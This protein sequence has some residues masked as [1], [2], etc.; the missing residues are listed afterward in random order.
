MV[1]V[2]YNPLRTKLVLSAQKMGIKA[3]C[4]LYMLIAQAVRASEIF[5]GEKYD[6]GVVGKV[7]RD[8]KKEK[9][10]VVLTGMPASGKS[11]VGKILAK[12]LNREFI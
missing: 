2:I 9:E 8:I 11:T 12:K 3:G 10:N 1:D 5:T 4:G 6:D 7:Y